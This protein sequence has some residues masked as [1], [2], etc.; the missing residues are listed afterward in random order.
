MKINLMCTFAHRTNIDIVTAYITKVYNPPCIHIQQNMDN[1]D[2][3]YCTFTNVQ[4]ITEITPSTI[5][6][7]RKKLT[8]TL[9]TINALNTLIR[10]INNGV[11]DKDYI[12]DWDLY[13]DAYL[14]ARDGYVDIV[15]IQLF[16]KV[17]NYDLPTF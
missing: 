5:S 4:G 2:N 10:S 3:L 9:Y 16:K 14:L 8:N 6:I 15:P 12:L 17:H 13:R 11:L 7:H 1:L